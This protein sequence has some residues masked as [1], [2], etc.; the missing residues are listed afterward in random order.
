MLAE[1]AKSRIVQLDLNENFI[2]EWSCAGEASAESNINSG[3]IGECCKGKRNKASGFKWM[4]YKDHVDT[5]SF[6]GC[7]MN[8]HHL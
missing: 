2:K 8:K 7:C 4:Y 3:N 1:R 5:F 6:V